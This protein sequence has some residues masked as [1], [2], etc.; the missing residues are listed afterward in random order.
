MKASKTKLEHWLELK[1][2]VTKESLTWVEDLDLEWD[3]I[4]TTMSNLNWKWWWS[5]RPP[6]TEHLK[7]VVADHYQYLKGADYVTGVGAGGFELTKY[8]DEVPRIR[9]SFVLTY[10]SKPF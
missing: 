3:K 2:R 8:T 6:T 7:Y 5:D 4:C 10:A 9:V 1:N